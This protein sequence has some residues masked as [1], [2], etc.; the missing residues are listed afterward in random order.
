LIF[1]RITNK[2]L[3]LG[4]LSLIMRDL[5]VILLKIKQLVILLIQ[6]TTLKGLLDVNLMNLLFNKKLKLSP[7]KFLKIKILMAVL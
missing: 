2:S 6:F 7:S 3:L 4:F 1:S 5:L